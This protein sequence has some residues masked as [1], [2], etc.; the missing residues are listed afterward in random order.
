[1]RTPRRSTRPG[2]E[3]SKGPESDP[4]P[5]QPS[6]KKR[7]TTAPARRRSAVRVSDEAP[8]ALQPPAFVPLPPELKR[9]AVDALAELLLP[10]LGDR[11]ETRAA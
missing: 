10:L 6:G 8:L 5:N 1:M 9:Q 3:K 7:R 11:S 2:L 4:L